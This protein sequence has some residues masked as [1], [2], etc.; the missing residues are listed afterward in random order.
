VD[1]H[2]DF[3]RVTVALHL[4]EVVASADAPE[5]GRHALVGAL[6]RGEIGVV[7][8][9]NVL[10]LAEVG[11]DA[12]GFGAEAQDVVGLLARELR[13]PIRAAVTFARRDASFDLGHPARTRVFALH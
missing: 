13:H 3:A 6:D 11:V 2:V 12:E 8:D 7:G 10:P 9:R 5:L 4:D 1:H